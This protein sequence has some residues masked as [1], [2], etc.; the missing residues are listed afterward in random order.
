MDETTMGGSVDES[1]RG[2]KTDSLGN[3]LLRHRDKEKPANKIEK[4]AF[5]KARGNH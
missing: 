1:K 4:T 2:L 5:N 3:P